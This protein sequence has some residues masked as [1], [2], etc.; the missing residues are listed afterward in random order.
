M[1]L[2]DQHVAALPWFAAYPERAGR[3]I[4]MVQIRPVTKRY[5]PGSMRAV[6]SLATSEVVG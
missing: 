5:V 3:D 2:W 4:P 6:T 1:R